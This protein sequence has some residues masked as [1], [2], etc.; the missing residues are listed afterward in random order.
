MAVAV[1]ALKSVTPAATFVGRIQAVNTVN[2]V[3]RADGFLEKRAFTEGQRVKKGDLLFVIEQDTYQAAAA[4]D[5]AQAGRQRAGDTA[6]RGARAA[7]IAGIGQDQRGRAGD[8]RSEPGDR[9]RRGG[10]R[11]LR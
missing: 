2:L 1:A 10:R 9:G 7:K 8:G 4:V 11:A 6:E 3:S 5:Q